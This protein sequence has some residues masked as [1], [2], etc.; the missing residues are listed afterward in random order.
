MQTTTLG[1]EPYEAKVGLIYIS[2]FMYAASPNCWNLYGYHLT[3]NQ[4]DYRSAAE[5]NWMNI[6]F[7]VTWTI[8]RTI[9]NNTKVYYIGSTGGVLVHTQSTQKFSDYSYAVRPTFYL[10]SNVTYAGGEGTKTNP[11]R[12]N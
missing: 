2:D 10:N 7:G 12:I 4:S 9:D 6:R 8:S 1:Y 5:D 11:Y 3:N